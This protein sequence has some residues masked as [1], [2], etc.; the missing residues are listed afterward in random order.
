MAK[1]V[2]YGCKCLASI[3]HSKTIWKWKT[4]IRSRKEDTIISRLCIGH[5]AVRSLFIKHK[6][7]NCNNC[8]IPETVEHILFYCEAYE[9]ERM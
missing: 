7:G 1:D 5:T 2:G 4:K 6:S 3:Q 8:G 9:R